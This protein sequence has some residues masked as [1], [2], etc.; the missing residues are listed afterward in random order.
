MVQQH[1]ALIRL[2]P[3][4]GV[5]LLLGG[6]P[7]PAAR[8]EPERET[9][10]SSVPPAAPQTQPQPPAPP[11]QRPPQAAPRE[12]RLS[13]ATRS[14]VTQAHT[15]LARGDT[16]GASSTLDRALRI[17]P[18]SPI[19]WTELGRVRLAENDPR[20]AESCARKALA[21]ASGDRTAQAP[22]GKLLADALRAQGR[23]PEAQ[24]VE[25]RPFMR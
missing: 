16:A 7:S 19:L 1:R 21:L 10:Q 24:E 17:E 11:L 20:Q 18:S 2:V 9:P 13:P 3:V 22:A 8:S 6:C 12:N 25:A 4:I 5:A 14:L 15:L 23:N